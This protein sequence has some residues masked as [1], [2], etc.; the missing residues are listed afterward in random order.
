M[1]RKRTT[2]R[3]SVE[4][5]GHELK[6]RCLEFAS[7]LDYQHAG[8]AGSLLGERNGLICRAVPVEWDRWLCSSVAVR[9][10]TRRGRNP[11]MPKNMRAYLLRSRRVQA[12]RNALPYPRPPTSKPQVRVDCLAKPHQS[13]HRSF[14]DFD[15]SWNVGRE[16]HRLR[17]RAIL[18]PVH[19]LAAR[20][21]ASV[22]SIALANFYEKGSS[23]ED[24]GRLKIL[25][26]PLGSDSGICY[27]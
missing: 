20:F 6:T 22:S 9:K 3:L 8:L 19:A 14:T 25:W 7:L 15:A 18:S 23:P 13:M 1:P 5:V 27:F 4:D 24:R 12:A 11:R 16:L 21:S 10:R 26:K 17:C 2:V